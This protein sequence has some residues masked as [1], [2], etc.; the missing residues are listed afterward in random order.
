MVYSASCFVFS[1]CVVVVVVV[2]A[3][4]TCPTSR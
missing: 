3:G 4:G 2:V 1:S